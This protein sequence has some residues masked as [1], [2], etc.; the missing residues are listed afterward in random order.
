MPSLNVLLFF[1]DGGGG[2]EM[3]E[4]KTL[5]QYLSSVYLVINLRGGG[6]GG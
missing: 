2:G 3:V 5:D 4:N 1:G 6:V